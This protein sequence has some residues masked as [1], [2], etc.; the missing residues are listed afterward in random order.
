M[1]G[2]RAL[3]AL[4]AAAVVSSGCEDIGGTDD[5]AFS[6]EPLVSEEIPTVITVEWSITVEGIDAARVEFGPDEEYGHSAPVDLTSGPPYETVLLGNKPSSDVHFRVVVEASG[7]ETASDDRV[8]ST[9]AVPT[10]MPDLSVEALDEVTD[11]FLVTS[12]FAVAPAAVIVDRDGDY[13]WWYEAPSEDFQVSRATLTADRQHVVFWSVNLSGGPGVGNAVDQELIRVSLDGTDVDTRAEEDGHHD[14]TV[15][16]D[17]G[18]THIEYDMRDGEEGDRIVEIGPDGDER[19]VWS[20]WDDYDSGGAG[21]PGTTLAHFN[22]IDYYEDEDAFYVSILGKENLVKIDRP[23]G[24]LVWAMGGDDSDF[25]LEDGDTDFFDRNHQFQ[26]L[27]DSLLMF[28]NGDEHANCSEAR[29]YAYSGDGGE[30]ELIWTYRPDPCVFSFSLGD[31][32]RLDDGHTLVTFSNQGQIDEVDAD[33]EL[34]WRLNASLGG[35]VGYTTFLEDL[36][37]S[38]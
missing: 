30:A 31:V 2:R 14:F 5:G 7:V 19:V 9:G 11:G 38:P 24:E 21:G 1:S 36:Y 29:E 18:I 12:L 3:L 22:A 34:V 32:S 33:G 20:F 13:V 37:A 8:D 10:D 23:G 26:R 28:V 27:D 4:M 16:P 17:G 25:V 6:I 35:A 15:M